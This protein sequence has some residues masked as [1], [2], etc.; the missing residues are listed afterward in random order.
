MR[1]VT[2]LIRPESSGM[3]TRTET[4]FSV[5][6]RAKE[7]TPDPVSP[8]LRK[9]IQETRRERPSGLA[10]VPA[11]RAV[12]VKDV[13]V[14]IDRHRRGCE[15]FEQDFLAQLDDRLAVARGRCLLCRK[16]EMLGGE[17]YRERRPRGCLCLDLP[18]DPALLVGERGEKAFVPAWGFGASEKEVS[19]FFK[20]IVKEGDAFLLG[21][22]LEVDEEIPAD[23]EVEPGEG[24]SVRISCLAN[25]TSCRIS[26]STVSER[27]SSEGVKK[28][29]R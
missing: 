4:G 18:V 13:V 2:C 20:G 14:L 10:Q 26:L 29:E 24:G 15:F 27:P 23:N 3:P 28:L 1:M 8:A 12:I 6:A 7:G 22:G 16:R 17:G 25:T 9:E 11:C 5:L 21:V 19:S